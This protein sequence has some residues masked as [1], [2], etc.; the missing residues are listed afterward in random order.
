MAKKDENGRVIIPDEI[1]KKVGVIFTCED[2][3]KPYFFL[4]YLG[5]VGVTIDVGRNFPKEYRH[6]GDC[7]FREVDHSIYIPENVEFAIGSEDFF[8]SVDKNSTMPILYLNSTNL[9]VDKAIRTIE[10]WVNEDIDE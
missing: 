5:E 9:K 7:D 8:F 6:L 2:D 3:F 4:N 1:Y 10:A